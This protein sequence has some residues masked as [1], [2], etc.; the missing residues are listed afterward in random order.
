MIKTPAVA[1][2]LHDSFYVYGLCHRA[3]QYFVSHR[4]SNSRANVT[5]A[6]NIVMTFY[7]DDMPFF[8]ARHKLK[9]RSLMNW[10]V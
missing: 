3:S 9:V 8:Q 6:Y 4:I 2:T 10:V 7:R 5:T 1:R